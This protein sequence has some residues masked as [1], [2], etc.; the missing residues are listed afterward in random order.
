[1]ADWARNAPPVAGSGATGLL[2]QLVQCHS[3]YRLYRGFN[4]ALL[5][6]TL[7]F[8]FAVGLQHVWAAAIGPGMLCLPQLIYVYSYANSDAGRSRAACCCWSSRW[9][10]AGPDRHCPRRYCWAC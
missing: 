10:S 7:G 5:A 2:D 3:G 1:M 6:V 8:L 4:V 9:P